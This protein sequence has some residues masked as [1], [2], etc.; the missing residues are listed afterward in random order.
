MAATTVHS[1]NLDTILMVEKAIHESKDY[2]T[3]MQLWESL[4]R[5]VQYQTFQ[6]ILEYLEASNK[7]MFDDHGHII[8]IAI[9]N[10]KLNALLRSGVELH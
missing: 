5:K 8:W 9:G 7:I 10:L 4:P 6:K 1:P 2:P 3:R